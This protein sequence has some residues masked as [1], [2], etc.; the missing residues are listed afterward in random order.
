MK[1]TETSSKNSSF[2]FLLRW[3]LKP[4]I[5]NDIQKNKS[6]NSSKNVF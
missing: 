4:K 1:N 5:Y 3:F 6:E 2:N